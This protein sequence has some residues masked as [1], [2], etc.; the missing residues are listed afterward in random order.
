VLGA[1]TLQMNRDHNYGG[2]VAN[3]LR[4]LEHLDV[5]TKALPSP[6]EKLS[7]LV[8]Y[9]AESEDLPLRARS[10]LHANCSHCHRKWAA[11]TPSSSCWPRSKSPRWE[12]SGPSGPRS[13]NI[14][15]ARILAPGDPYRSVLF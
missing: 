4:T 1:Q 3:Q 2:T 15:H 13:F 8:D 6:P 10:Y 5:F 7:R 14:P 12:P 9:R 11:A